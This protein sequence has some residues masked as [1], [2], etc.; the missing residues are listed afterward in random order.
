MR[1]TEEELIN[2][3]K[4]EFFNLKCCDSD[5]IIKV[6]EMFYNK[7][8]GRVYI[9]MEYCDVTKLTDLVLKFGPLDEKLVCRIFKCTLEAILTMQKSGICHRYNFI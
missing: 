1:T 2:Q 4:N 7:V 8:K 3:A 6:Y 5:Y 9:V